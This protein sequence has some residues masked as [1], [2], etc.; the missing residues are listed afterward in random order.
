MSTHTFSNTSRQI[1]TPAV[2][3]LELDF[4]FRPPPGWS[5]APGQATRLLHVRTP[6]GTRPKTSEV[7]ELKVSGNQLLV[8]ELSG[9]G[10]RRSEFREP[11]KMQL[12]TDDRYSVVYANGAVTV[13]GR[14]GATHLAP[15]GA[16]ELVFGFDT[17]NGEL[18]AP[19]GWTL[20]FEGLSTRPG[21]QPPPPPPPP[22]PDG[23]E[24]NAALRAD[25]QALLTKYALARGVD[26][27]L[28]AILQLA[29]TRR[30]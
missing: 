29:I 16:L 30:G 1:I 8:V 9:F 20:D 25:L 10:S 5:P 26:P 18:G 6:G 28:L 13:N 4:T 12:P 15:S 14:T 27:L 17:P 11:L 23:G 24:A 2:A 3:P 19:I 7:F 21:P 22:P